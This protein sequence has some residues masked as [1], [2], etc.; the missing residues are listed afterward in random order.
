M[1]LSFAAGASKFKVVRRTTASVFLVVRLLFGCP[2]RM[3]NQ[4]FERCS[5]YIMFVFA[6]E[7]IMKSAISS[8]D[9]YNYEI[10]LGL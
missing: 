2:G 9:A 8:H 3:D 6:S 7:V 1:Q 4:N 10:V 5:S